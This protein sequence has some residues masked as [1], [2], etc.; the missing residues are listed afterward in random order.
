M[1]TQSKFLNEDPQILGDLVPWICAPHYQPV[2]YIQNV[3][4]LLH[5]EEYGCHWRF[6]KGAWIQ[7]QGQPI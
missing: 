7:S 3:I 1:L 6:T 5:T 4:L 2:F